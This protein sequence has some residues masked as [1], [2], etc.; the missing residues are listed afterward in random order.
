MGSTSVTSG[1]SSEFS[2][3]RQTVKHGDESGGTRAKYHWVRE[4]QKQFSSQPFEN[5]LTIATTVS[6]VTW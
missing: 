4:D 3:S 5:P 2:H 1:K 6:I